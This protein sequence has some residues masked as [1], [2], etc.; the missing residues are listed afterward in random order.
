MA[1]TFPES[2]RIEL[3]YDDEE[4][5]VNADP[6]RMQQVI[7]NLALNARDAM[8]NKGRRLIRL[9]RLE[10]LPDRHPPCPGMTPGEWAHIAVADT[11]SGIPPDVLPHIFE[12][13]FTTKPPGQGTGLGLAQVYGIVT[14]HGGYVDV[15]TVAGQG[16]T[17]SIYLPVDP[18]SEVETHLSEEYNPVHGRGETVLL[19]EDDE[20]TRDAVRDSLEA[21]N[22]RVI[23]ATNGLEAL[24]VYSSTTEIDLV[25]TDVVMPEMGG[26]ELIEELRKRNHLAR[27]VAM[28]G[29]A[30][31]EEIQTLKGE[32]W[33]EVLQKPL[34]VNSLSRTISRALR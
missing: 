11:G 8:S 22:Y 20:P 6:T 30:V 26:M 12:P 17:F 14:Q 1:R 15:Q 2:V 24:E 32:M 27:A 28:T 13:F 7:M 31:P 9:R 16:T 3:C 34:N 18:V 21:L 5:V 29:Y 25:L 10:L 4:Y 33:I 19:V 23:E